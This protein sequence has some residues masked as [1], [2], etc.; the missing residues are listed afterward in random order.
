MKNTYN[1][2]TCI[3]RR[4]I[5]IGSSRDSSSR[6]KYP[7]QI[8]AAICRDAKKIPKKSFL[9]FT[10]AVLLLPNTYKFCIHD[11]HIC[12]FPY[13]L[14]IYGFFVC[15]TLWYPWHVC[16]TQYGWYPESRPEYYRRQFIAHAHCIEYKMCTYKRVYTY[17]GSFIFVIHFYC[18][19]NI[20][21]VI[22]FRFLLIKRSTRMSYKFC[23]IWT[24]IKCVLNL[25]FSIFH[26]VSSN[27]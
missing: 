16:V 9:I 11:I 20:I 18:F 6:D 10:A 2:Y 14:C 26:S 7:L 5:L 1:F 19:K 3:P 15:P 21:Y 13:I 4:S 24:V 12:F 27:K 8:C 23:R 17:T 22:K 25:H